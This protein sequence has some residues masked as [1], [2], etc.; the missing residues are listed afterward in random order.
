M[1]NA[2]ISG[3]NVLRNSI[4]GVMPLYI[5]RAAILQFYQ[6]PPEIKNQTSPN[7]HNI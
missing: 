3:Q 5:I 7:V 1:P 6:A 4:I 2:T